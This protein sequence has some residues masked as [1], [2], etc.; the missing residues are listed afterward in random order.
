MNTISP[1]FGP[2]GVLYLSGITQL[3]GTGLN[4]LAAVPT[5]GLQAP[6][7]VK[8]AITGDSDYQLQEGVITGAGTVAPNDQSASSKTWVQVQ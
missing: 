8:I 7:I 6:Y 1:V 4:A 5:I 2:Q 3:T